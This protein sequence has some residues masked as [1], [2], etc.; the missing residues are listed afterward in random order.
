MTKQEFSRQLENLKKKKKIELHKHSSLLK[1]RNARLSGQYNL[2]LMGGFF[3]IILPFITLAAFLHLK[4]DA[5]MGKNSKIQFPVRRSRNDVATER[6]AN[7]VLRL[8]P[9]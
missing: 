8:V 3:F 1:K 2:F 9:Y 6:K 4:R 5:D 7:T